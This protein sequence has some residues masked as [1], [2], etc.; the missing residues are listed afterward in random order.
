MAGYEMCTYPNTVTGIGDQ[1]KVRKPVIGGSLRRA[2]C[3]TGYHVLFISIQ[4][5]NSFC[6]C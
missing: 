1:L 5:L 3:N 4:I 6:F 2:T